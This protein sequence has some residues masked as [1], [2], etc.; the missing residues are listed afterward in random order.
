M[1][2]GGLGIED[3]DPEAADNNFDDAESIFNNEETCENGG[4]VDHGQG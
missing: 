2:G 4:Y 3:T 1:V